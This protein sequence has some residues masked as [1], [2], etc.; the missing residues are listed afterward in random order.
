VDYLRCDDDPSIYSKPSRELSDTVRTY[1]QHESMPL[2]LR[3]LTTL[4]VVWLFVE[5]HPPVIVIT[6]GK[7]I[8]LL[9]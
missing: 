1:S 7:Q 2:W 3:V 9:G 8:L 5:S 4:V 6:M